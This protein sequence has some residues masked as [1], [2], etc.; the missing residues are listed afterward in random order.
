[1]YD[2][3]YLKIEYEKQNQVNICTIKVKYLIFGD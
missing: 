1:M 2:I 3:I